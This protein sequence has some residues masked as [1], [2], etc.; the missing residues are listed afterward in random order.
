[1]VFLAP[2]F[3]WSQNARMEVSAR[4]V[5]LGDRLT[6]QIEVSGARS[7][8]VLDVGLQGGRVVGEQ[9]FTSQSFRNRAS[10]TTATR[11]LHVQAGQTGTMT[12]GPVHYQSDRETGTLP[13]VTVEVVDATPGSTPPQAGPPALPQRTTQRAPQPLLRGTD[14]ADVQ[15]GR[16]VPSVPPTQDAR[17]YYTPIPAGSPVE[18]FVRVA[19]SDDTL[20]TGQQLV[21]DYLLYVPYNRPLD[22]V[23]LS[24]PEF[25]GVWYEQVTEQ[26]LGRRRLQ[27]RPETIGNTLFEVRPLASFIAVPW[28]PGELTIPS[29][30]VTAQPQTWGR[31]AAP[32]AI[33]SSTGTVQVAALPAGDSPLPHGMRHNV[34]AFSFHA[35]L[36]PPVVR[37]GEPVTLTLRVQGA[38]WLARLGLPR[39]QPTDELRVTAHDPR[40][41][42]RVGDSGWLEGTVLQRI[43]LVPQTAGEF[44]L[45][46]EAFRWFDPWTDLYAEERAALP[47]LRVLPAPG[48]DTAGPAAASDG[49][50]GA[51]AAGDPATLETPAWPPLRSIPQEPPPPRGIPPWTPWLGGLPL[52]ALLLDIGWGMARRL[53]RTRT[54]HSIWKARHREV[55]VLL[56]RDTPD[57]AGFRALQQGLQ[58][59]LGLDNVAWS[60]PRVTSTLDALD[61]GPARD[62][63]RALV[64][65][66]ARWDDAR[67]SGGLPADERRVVLQTLREAWPALQRWRQTP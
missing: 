52:L 48:G 24:E 17:M 27:A 26:R 12:I 11:T 51:E 14:A 4:E 43:T 54:P 38:G 25:T 31:R 7:A 29:L 59:W 32:V 9:T 22:L 5:R 47:M 61:A 67:W 39:L 23:D 33:T 55:A 62:A 36:Q 40:T 34:G 28:E 6:V 18:P 60:V 42:A 65:A 8:R 19:V 44:A 63:A 30:T 41:D 3:A 21:V 58:A 49:A 15:D 45:D 1:M 50:E 35:T 16:V 20:Y 13:A 10:V 37:V 53:R 66:L 56:A 2:T 46:L 57:D 64:A